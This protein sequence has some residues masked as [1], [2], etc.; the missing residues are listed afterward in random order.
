MSEFE[1]LFGILRGRRS[2]RLFGKEPV[3]RELIEKIVEAAAWAPSASNRQDWEFTVVESHAVKRSMGLAVRRRWDELLARPEAQ[4]VGEELRQHARF[5]AW[6]ARA[7]LVI[8]VSARE[9][10]GYMAALCGE[11]AADVAG[12]KVSAAMAAQNLMLAAHALGLG[13]CCLTAPLAAP[14]ELK[15]LLGLGRRRELVCLIALGWPAGEA[16]VMP[17]KEVKEVMRI[18]E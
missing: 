11:A 8:A 13:T 17:R 2:V 10:D 3:P 15:E 9:P 7:P 14:E 12:Q 1:T 18:I 16:P 5:F 6:F 4:S